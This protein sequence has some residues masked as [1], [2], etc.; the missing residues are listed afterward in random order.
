MTDKFEVYQ[1]AGV[2]E[3]W[4]VQPESEMILVYV[5]N[6]S[7]EYQQIRTKP[8]LNGE[9]VPVAVFPGFEIILEDVF[10]KGLD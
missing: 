5:L 7:G 4:V 6:E 2:K 10:P 9:R 3:Y 1:N 8:F